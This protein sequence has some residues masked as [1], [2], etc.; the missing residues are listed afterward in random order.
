MDKDVVIKN[1]DIYYLIRRYPNNWENAIILYIRCV[2][3]KDAGISEFSINNIMGITGWGKHKV[4]V[5][6]KIL[7]ELGFFSCYGKVGTQHFRFNPDS[8]LTLN[9]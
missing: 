3:A 4:C 9:K 1:A 5:H 8:Y 7:Q 6:R 2:L